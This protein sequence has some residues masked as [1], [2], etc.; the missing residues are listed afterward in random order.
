MTLML[1]AFV[2]LGGAELLVV[3][4]RLWRIRRA[5]AVIVATATALITGL[6]LGERYSLAMSCIALLSMYRVINMMRVVENRTE[7]HRLRTSTR[8]NTLGLFAL[9]I[10]IFIALWIADTLEP[11]PDTS[12]LVLS[13]ILLVFATGVFWTTRRQL[14]TTTA[15]DVSEHFSDARLPSLSVC[16]PARNETASLEECLRTLIASDYPKL[17]ILVLDDC[18]QASRTSDVIKG[19][20]H[21]GVRFIKGEAA[22]D[23]WLAK[24]WAYQ[25]L[26]DA[27]S[28]SHI[29][30]CGADT[31]FEPSTLRNTV[32]TLLA[33]NKR[34]LSVIPRNDLSSGA[35]N[36]ASLLIQP[37]RY[38]WELCLPRRLFNRPPVLS[39]YW[40]AERKLIEGAGTFAAVTHSISPEAYFAHKAIIRDGYSFLRSGTGLEISSKKDLQDQW[41]TAVRTRYPQLRR[42]IDLVF[43]VSIIEIVVTAA[44]TILLVAGLAHGLWIQAATAGCTVLV[45][46]ITYCQVVTL[47]YRRRLLRGLFLLS[48]AFALDIVIRHISMWRY[49]FGEVTWKGRNV[50]L[51]VMQ[52]SRRLP[53]F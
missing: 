15:N 27:S 31:R 47:T 28:G 42:R 13:A 10:C 30:F 35:I 29:L 36:K 33:R 17:E 1:G 44:P 23:D 20:A 24:N 43:I 16:I 25:Q 50:C 52:V 38:A 46:S 41:D 6:L 39:T 22:P 9:Q 8:K 2:L 51:P 11:N 48:F 14:R 40:L 19:F 34:M 37:V 12:W 45:L 4:R 53:K 49:E 5:L 7:E 32:T 21:D 3:S 26:F 18:S